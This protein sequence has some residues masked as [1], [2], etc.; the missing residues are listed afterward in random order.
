MRHLN[1]L[2]WKIKLLGG[3]LV[4]TLLVGFAGFIGM[5]DIKTINTNGN[6]IYT[7]N[8]LSIKDLNDIRATFLQNRSTM[9]LLYY[10]Q[11]KSKQETYIQ[12][13]NNQK[14]QN[15]VYE[16]N[17]EKTY[18]NN[19]SSEEKKGYN[20]FRTNQ[21]NYRNQRDNMIKSLNEGSYD[22]AGKSLKQALAANDNAIS[23]LNKLVSLNE[24][25]AHDK[26]AINQNVYIHSYTMLSIVIGVSIIIAVII[27]LFLSLNLSK[28]LSN[29]VS[30]AEALGNEDLT[31]QLVI[32][33]NDEIGQLGVS[34]NKATLSMKKLV[35]AIGDSCQTM[36][37]HSEELSANMEEITATIETV[38]HSTEQIAQGA[39][40]LGANTEEVSASTSEVLKF[41]NQVKA[42]AEEGQ[43]NAM[44]I[45]ERASVV[46][47]RGSLAINESSRIY[48]E[49]ESKIKQ[50]LEDAKVVSEIKLMAET[51]GGISEQT[52]LLSLNASIEAARAGDAGRGFAVVADEVRK[53][54]EQSKQAVDNINH[55]IN[56]VQNAFNNLLDNTQELLGFL[57]TTVQP[58][59]EAYA[60]TGIQYEKDSE[61]VDGM[62]RELTLATESMSQLVYQISQAIQNV[63]A[64][65]QE[66]A[67]SSEEI[68]AGIV[69]TTTSMEQVNL[70]AQ[71][72]AQL[73]EKLSELVGKF[74]V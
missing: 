12:Q 45:K 66:S 52:N 36:N 71:S 43:K 5:K 19:L 1:D 18:L 47:N 13:I 73:A 41:T 20:D 54:A 9:I 15:N 22:Q 38:Q 8:L 67:S 34:I 28:R 24:R 55:V 72:Q 60:Q 27:G 21:D 7:D 16:Q 14:A 40:E 6:S 29:I 59:Y 25:K 17:Y 35:E 33:G 2:S 65:A 48:S 37:A 31:Q 56:K 70:A 11:D 61:Y 62:S 26:E 32:Y 39:E 50:A 58:D 23:A 51:I 3:F 68:S 74:K 69:Q 30:F 53:L 42:K 64:T 10:N 4:L 46:K 44:A 57:E 63:T 49:K